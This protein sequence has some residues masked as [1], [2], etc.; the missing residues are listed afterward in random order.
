MAELPKPHEDYG[1][2]VKGTAINTIRAVLKL[3]D[4]EAEQLLSVLEDH[5]RVNLPFKRDDYD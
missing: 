2:Y 3:T 5:M 1:G 4:E